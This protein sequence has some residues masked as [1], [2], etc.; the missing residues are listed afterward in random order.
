VQR[1]TAGKEGQVKKTNGKKP[2][3]KFRPAPHSIQSTLLISFSLVS[4]ISMVFLCLLLYGQFSRSATQMASDNSARLLSQSATQLENY[5]TGMRRIS[6]AMYYDMIR[7]ADLSDKSVVSESNLLYEANRDSVVSLALFSKSGKLIF[8]S[9]TAVEKANPDVTKQEWF[10]TAMDQTENLHFSTPHVQRIFDDT[11]YRYYWVISLSRAVMLSQN[12][13]PEFGVLLVDMDYSAVDQMLSEVNNKNTKQY[14]YLCDSTGQLIYH[15]R[16]MQINSGLYTEDNQNAAALEDGVH[17]LSFGG[18]KRLEVVNTVSYTGWKLIYVIP[19]KS[20]FGGMMRTRY[21]AGLIVM[22]M[23]FTTLLLNRLVSGRVTK[24]L[25]QLANSIRENSLSAGEHRDGPPQ[26]YIGGSSEVQYLGQT[27]QSFYNR[28]Y[29]LM[30]DI[31]IEQEKKQKSEL[32]ALQSQINPHFL[33]NTLDSIVWMIEGE[34]YKEAVFMITQLASLFRI[35]LAK[36][37]TIIRIEEELHHAEN[38]SNIQKIRF[39]DSFTVKFEAADEVLN[40]CTVKLIVQPLL[41]NAIYY[42][43]KDMDEGGLITV[44]AWK[45]VDDGDI[46]I[47]VTDNG[48]GMPEDQVKN[49]LTDNQSVRKNG[50]GVGLLNVHNRI[51]LRFGEAYGLVIRSEPDEGTAVTIHLPAIP[52][53]DETAKALEEG[54]KP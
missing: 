3:K 45:D 41:E 23:L 20:V 42:G 7:D 2:N 48:Y 38:Y 37:R 14:M 50:S 21:F 39:R 29:R 51:R 18:E 26:V 8:A 47:S 35:S 13:V 22:L 27:V 31:V 52:Y 19:M 1:R 9:P 32:D 30:Q 17:E 25:R 43:V 49:L 6:D 36:G 15:P 12:G 28:N 34:R 5:L 16:Q 44:R 10:R 33:Y 11:S 24:P 53:T 40:C 46:Y 54:K 4:L